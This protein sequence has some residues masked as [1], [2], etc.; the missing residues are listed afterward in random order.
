METHDISIVTTS[1]EKLSRTNTNEATNAQSTLES[2]ENAHPGMYP[3]SQ[4][5]P[6]TN[7]TSQ[8]STQHLLLCP[9]LRHGLLVAKFPEI[10]LPGDAHVQSHT[11]DDNKEE[12][13][14]LEGGVLLV[15]AGDLALDFLLDLLG[16]LFLAVAGGPVG[17]AVEGLFYK[18]VRK[19]SESVSGTFFTW[20]CT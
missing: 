1:N 7:H 11:P 16:G 19:T 18:G 10:P 20:E 6:L 14:L 17:G 12:E 4:V 9:H 3:E 13:A 15:G 5:Y 2:T 8:S